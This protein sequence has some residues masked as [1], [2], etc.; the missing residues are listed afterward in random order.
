MQTIY[1]LPESIKDDLARFEEEIKQFKDGTTSPTEFR[2]F[3]VPQGVY[4]QREEGIFMLRVRLA[5]GGVLPHQMR[6][7]ASASRK[8]GNGI[9][10]ATTRQ[11]IQIHRVTIDDIHPALM[12]LYSAGLSTKGGGGNTVRNIT[13]CYDAGV[14]AQEAFDVAP[15]AVAVT[16]FM[17]PDPVNYQLPRKYK[18]AFSGCPDDC[19]GA[20]VNDL[21]C[22]AKKRGDEL[23]F[24]VHVGGGLG[25]NSRV[26]KSFLDFV[27]AGEIHLVAEAVKR[28][29]DKHGNRKNKHRARLRFL[30]EQM[31]LERFREL[32]EAEL[33][34]LRKNGLSVLKV[35]D[36]PSRDLTK[37]EA[38]ASPHDGFAVWREKNTEPQKQSGYYMVHIPL[39][40]GDITADTLEKLADVVE[41]HGEG[42][43]RTTQSQNMV[44]RWVH[45]N[46]L[47]ALHGKLADLELA[48]TPAPILRNTVACAGAAT[49]KLGICLSRGLARA[50]TNKLSSDGLDLDGLGELNINI[51]GCPNSCGRHPI[52]QI[53][54]FGAARR[55]G[56]RLVPHYVV[57]LGGRVSEGKTKLAQGKTTI[58]AHNIPGFIVDFLRAFQDSPQH[59]DYDAFLEAQGVDIA[60][61]LADKHKHIPSF[62]EDKNHYFDYG[63]ESL[64]S[65]AGR[66]PGEC[67][68]GVF[69]LIEV[70]L[71]SAHEA[72]EKGDLFSAT[73]LSTRALLVTQGQEAKDDVEAL[74]LFDKWFIESG[75]VSKTFR[76]LIESVRSSEGFEADSGDVSALV[77]AVQNLYDNMDQSLRFQPVTT[78]GASEPEDVSAAHT[79]D[80][81][82]AV[83]READFRG[84]VCPLNYVK[85][86]LLLEQMPSGQ[87]LAIL[88]DEEGGRNVPE[89]ASQDGHEVLSQKKEGEYWRVVV[90]KG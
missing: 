24:A 56:G 20:T 7:L 19:A 23:G 2:T 10:H 53:G 77:N 9:L 76:T 3:R 43:A 84:V 75:L 89:S 26:A 85:T 67:G 37:T 74:D 18:I 90:R 69:D 86:K 41:I 1:N 60:D 14:C 73:V 44:I 5:A 66:G 13:A 39:L 51:S 12:E 63:A 50:I 34:G 62:E 21:G 78:E 55:I 33:S 57:Q 6:T 68:A 11:D 71:A 48:E 36:L 87:V 58:P 16:E 15:Y 72:L 45:E 59:P 83:D 65:L 81:E 64:F 35:R 29:F 27:P 28:V 80:D 54:L 25:A 32:Y 42:M 38:E 82:I 88:L 17:L 40:L 31:G 70:D 4:E 79:A 49:C 52:G 61:Q 30:I 46:E 22:I 8:Y 47:A